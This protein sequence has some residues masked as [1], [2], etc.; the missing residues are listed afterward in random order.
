MNSPENAP[1]RA[2]NSI[3]DGKV[4]LSTIAVDKEHDLVGAI[5]V[6]GHIELRR[7]VLFDERSNGRQ[8]RDDRQLADGQRQGGQLAQGLAPELPR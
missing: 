6:V 7:L 3:K 8:C 2:I 5:W 1:E 4:S